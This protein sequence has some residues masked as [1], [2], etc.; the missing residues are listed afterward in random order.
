MKNKIENMIADIEINLP[1][2]KIKMIWKEVAFYF[3]K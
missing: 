3:N 1:Q 2:R